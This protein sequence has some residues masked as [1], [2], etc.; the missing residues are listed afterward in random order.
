[1]VRW[2][3]R[4]L[5]LATWLAAF[6]E[7]SSIELCEHN[8][9]G[10][11]M[12]LGDEGEDSVALQMKASQETKPASRQPAELLEAAPGRKMT[13]AN[14]SIRE[15]NPILENGT[16]H[17]D[18]RSTPPALLMMDASLGELADAMYRRMADILHLSSRSSA[19]SS[20]AD[21]GLSSDSDAGTL[22]LFAVLF[23]AFFLLALC[24]SCSLSK[25]ACCP[26]WIWCF[27]PLSFVIVYLVANDNYRCDP[28]T[29]ANGSPPFGGELLPSYYTMRQRMNWFQLSKHVDVFDG[30]GKRIGYFYDI[31]FIF[32]SRF[33][34]AD[35][36]HRI[37]FEAQRY[38][39]WQRPTWGDQFWLQRCDVNGGSR[40]ASIYDVDEDVWA[41]PFICWGGCLRKYAVSKRAGR[42]YDSKVRDV[43]ATVKF[44]S[45]F[46]SWQG[47]QRWFMDMVDPKDKSVF[48][49]AQQHFTCEGSSLFCI[50]LSV[51]TVNITKATIV[52]NWVV[53]FMAAL[54]DIDEDRQR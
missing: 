33:G 34:F 19:K 15:L 40:H 10:S 1:M 7:A 8:A 50:P 30:N 48:G 42:G 54:D 39:L 49:R 35:S 17:T 22:V 23:A 16:K 36:A 44:N 2:A 43:V 13:L 29:L 32:L 18:M 31:N 52:P 45:T 4:W 53:G 24:A 5:S 14:P 3:V 20:Q 11:A 12:C 21:V 38:W 6:G 47:R 37:W 41:R 28:Y 51:W 26:I 46:N 9:A 27:L 25:G